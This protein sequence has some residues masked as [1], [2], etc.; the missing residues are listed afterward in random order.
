MRLFLA[1]N[2]GD[3]WRRELAT[4]IDPVR[5][6][7]DSCGALRWSRPDNWHLTLQFLGDWPEDRIQPL[8][9]ALEQAEVGGSFILKPGSLG[10]FPELARPRV[11][12]LH[13]ASDGNAENLARAV[14]QTVARTWPAG[15]QDTRPFRAHL[16]L[17]RVHGRLKEP[18]QEVLAE[19][20]LA[21]LPEIQVP[22][23]RLVTSVLRPEGAEH[24]NLALF[25]LG[26]A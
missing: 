25:S 17:A 15:P 10:A 21:G 2:P 22:E 13:L 23:F 6:R 5:A 12:F 9:W 14:R 7:L 24:R 4:R 8:K 18:E 1:V 26:T 19:L 16:T 20:D 3:Q 11:L